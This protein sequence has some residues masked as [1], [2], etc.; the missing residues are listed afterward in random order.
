MKLRKNPSA[1]ISAALSATA[2]ALLLAAPSA[3]QSRPAGVVD[4]WSFHR[5]VYSSPGTLANAM[6]NGTLARWNNIVN[7]PRYQ[8]ELKRRNL[9]QTQQARTGGYPITKDWTEAITSAGVAANLTG[10]IGTLSS[11]SIGSGSTLTID[12]VTFTASP[13][14]AETATIK[15]SST[16]PTNA[17]SVT[18]GSVVYTFETSN[19]TTAPAT[20]C[21]VYS[22]ASTTGA[23]SLYQAITFTGTQGSTN[24]RCATSITTANGAVTASQSTSTVSLTATTPG[25]AGFT[26]SD[27]GTTNFST[28]SSTAGSNGATSG[29]TFAYWSGATYV[30]S[31][32]V[33]TNIATVVNANATVSAILTAAA[34]TPASGDVT[35]TAK[36]TGVNGNSYEVTANSLSAFTPSSAYLSGGGS[37]VQPNAFPAKFSFS[38]TSASCADFVVYPTGA[39]GASN[40][41]NLVS[42][43]N[44]YTGTCTGTVPAVSWAYNTGGVVTTSPTLSA[45]GSQIAF[46]QVTGTTASL[47][48]LKPSSGGSIS[49]PVTL[50]AQA[51]ASAY[52]SCTAPCF[53][54]LS[55]SANDTF[56]APFYD[57]LRDALYVG[58]DSGN[59][60]QFF[61]VFNGTPSEN[62]TSPWPVHLGSNKISSPVYDSETGFQAG[63][64]FVGDMGG[65]FYSV[66][67]GY[68][69]TTSGNIYGNTG[70]LGQAI[71]DAPLVD[72]P[73]GVEYVFV[74]TNGSYSW[75]GYDAVW[76]FV[77]IFTDVCPIGQSCAPGVVEV[78]LGGTG[79]YLYA[80]AF[81][82]VYF[83][84]SPPS[85]DSTGSIYV[86]GNT[87]TAGGATLYQVPISHSALTGASN[88]VATGLNSTEYP[89]PSPATEFCNGA[90]ASNGTETT[91]GTDYLFFSVNRGAKP[92]C[93]NAAG[94]GCIM[95]YN[96]NNPSAVS[97]AGTGLNVAAPG[98]KGC[99]ATG[100]IVIDNSSAAAGA[101]QIYFVNLNGST[102]GGA[103]GAT[104]SNCT[105][106]S[107]A[108][109][110]GVQAAQSNP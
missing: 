26:F 85:P 93:T 12:G 76:E 65:V 61:G 39:P 19:I 32:Q 18:I 102:A 56:S 31:S 30:S 60:H 70:S 86:V 16:K 87:G 9:A 104:S 36:T 46:M 91:S 51:S 6:K 89:F 29:T 101:S 44:L 27:S 53:Y 42:Y 83:Q 49:A 54:A 14:T 58:D 109:V 82:N 78:G 57:Y 25:S 79:Y 110:N 43:A 100:G 5:L 99:W 28:F 38:T 68:G 10:V 92:G 81:D 107:G 106:A 45:D 62:K 3:A 96:I 1:P 48:L 80:G 69:G 71:A 75:P 103:T 90:C 98:T 94:N 97:Q 88:Q 64:I 40:A 50:T 15:F 33:A 22:A 47:V 24:Y 41:A 35:F 73:Q 95:S 77:S 11:S 105:A 23:T 63:F 55:L 8:M 72:C 4:D 2:L 7:D 67:S 13:P 52:R 108:S 84:S 66:G 21:Q 74:T 34:N 59:L 17:S 20:G 37:G